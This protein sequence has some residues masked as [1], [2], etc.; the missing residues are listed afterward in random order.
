[1][2]RLSGV[3]LRSLQRWA[4][5]YHRD[6][7][8]GLARKPR[9]DAGQRKVQSELFELIEG[10]ALHKPKL[11]AAAMHRRIT[12]IATARDWPVPS[13]AAVHAIVNALDPGLVTLAH[14]GAAA[15][16]DRFEMI[17]RHRAEEPNA[18]WQ[19]DH[20]QLDLL[21]LDGGPT[22]GARQDRALLWHHQ[23]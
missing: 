10:L 4:V 16:R 21:I 20:T 14:D 18:V 7:F 15:C 1:M 12:P 8:V 17:H 23:H 19:A 3:P 11:T 13:Y 5:R 6:G 9:A 2:A 22:A